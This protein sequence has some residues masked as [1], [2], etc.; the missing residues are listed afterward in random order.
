MAT[1]SGQVCQLELWMNLWMSFA[2]LLVKLLLK[3]LAL[4]AAMLGIVP[5]WLV[6]SRLPLMVQVMRTSEIGSW[7]WVAL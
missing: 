2:R 7:P 5:M 4:K 6:P 1:P 3:G